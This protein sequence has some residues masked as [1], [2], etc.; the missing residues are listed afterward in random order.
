MRLVTR[1]PSDAQKVYVAAGKKGVSMRLVTRVPSDVGA[2]DGSENTNSVSMR[3]VTRVPSDIEVH[4][5]DPLQLDS[6]DAV[7]YP[8]SFRHSKKPAG[9]GGMGV[10]RCG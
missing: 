2:Q 9:D 6:L 4:L 5:R 7:S 8:R 1:V 3:L 10:S